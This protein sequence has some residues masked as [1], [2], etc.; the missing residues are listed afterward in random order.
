MSAPYFEFK[1]DVGMLVRRDFAP[2]TSSD[3]QPNGS[4]PLVEGEFLQI[5]SSEFKVERGGDNN[6][7]TADAT[8][9]PCFPVWAE[10]GRYD[11]QGLGKVPVIYMGMYE[12]ETQ[13]CDTTGAAPG[14]PLTVVDVT[15][16]SL[17]RR[18]L[19]KTSTSGN[20][21]VG[22]VVKVLSGKIRFIHTG[23]SKL[24]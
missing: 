15:H 24:P 14:D 22:W 5:D 12:A 3:L 17:V 2:V 18:G 11:V 1:S 13:I 8:T 4:R 16:G 23:F 21:V 7:G 9:V 6:A 10:R 19:K 20:M